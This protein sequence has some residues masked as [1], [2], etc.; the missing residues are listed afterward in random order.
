MEWLSF[1]KLQAE[2]AKAIMK[3]RKV[4]RVASLLRMVQVCSVFVLI[5]RLWMLLAVEVRNWSEYLRDLS[6]LMKNPG[7]VF[8]IGNVIIMA[9]LAQ[10]SA[11]S[12][13]AESDVYEDLVGN[14]PKVHIRDK[15]SYS[16]KE[17]R[18]EGKANK[19][20]SCCYR[21]CDREILREKRRRVLRRCETVP[22][23]QVSRISCPEDGLSNEEFRLTVEAFIAR[24]QRLRR[25]EED[26]YYYLM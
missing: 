8:V 15:E 20:I 21:R 23:E 9:L 3:S 16:K 6:L 26:Y 2:K 10:F 5:S 13:V 7:F 25:E 19:G 4:Q 1:R 22:V 24:Q 18:G 11:Q 14:S 17:Q 12:N